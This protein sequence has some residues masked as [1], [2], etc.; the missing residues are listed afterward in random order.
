MIDPI[1]RPSRAGRS[2]GFGAVLCWALIG[3]VAAAED[4]SLSAAEYISLGM[5]AADRTWGG[6]EYEA[7]ASALAKI[8]A[9]NPSQLPRRGSAKS[10]AVFE[11]LVSPDNLEFLS[12]SDLPAEARFVAGLPTLQAQPSI[13]GIYLGVMETMNTGPEL[14]DLSRFQLRA[15]AAVTPLVRERM[16]TNDPSDPAREIQLGG[17]EQVRNGVATMLFGTLETLTERDAFSTADRL[18]LAGTV[19]E[20]LPAF[21]GMLPEGSRK[22][23][24]E[25]LRQ[26]IQS[27]SDPELKAIL[28]RLLAQSGTP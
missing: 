4:P 23:L 3:S 27:E 15:A 6:T 8:A 22:E 21:L 11:R 2:F 26:V 9:A 25:R 18:R 5:P 19:E 28:S 16:A 7:A 10:G 14:I 20:V 1:R 24:P 13:F 17:Y 12:N